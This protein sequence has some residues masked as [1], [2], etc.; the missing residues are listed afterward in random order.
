MSSVFGCV[1]ACACL[2]V[3][4]CASVRVWETHQEEEFHKRIVDRWRGRLHQKDVCVAH[5]LAQL[6]LSSGSK[7]FPEHMVEV[8]VR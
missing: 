1:C 3:Q 2:C 6:F 4:S 8:G 7:P 5:V